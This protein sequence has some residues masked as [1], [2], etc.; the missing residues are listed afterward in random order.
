MISR[1]SVRG[2]L[3]A[4][5]TRPHVFSITCNL[6]HSSGGSNGVS[7]RNTAF[8]NRGSVGSGHAG[9]SKKR[10]TAET[11]MSLL[12]NDSIAACATSSGVTEFHPRLLPIATR[13]ISLCFQKVLQSLENIHYSNFAGHGVCE[14]LTYLIG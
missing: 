10:D 7:I 1:S 4:A 11:C 13:I 2:A 6:F 5:R 3:G 14:R 8:T 9:A 12:R